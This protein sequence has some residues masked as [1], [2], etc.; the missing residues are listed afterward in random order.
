MPA[1]PPIP[2]SVYVHLPWCPSKCP[3]CDFNSYAAR[4]M[5]ESAYVDALL[6]DLDADAPQVGRRIVQSI[7]VGGGTPSLFESGSIA[8]LLAGLRSRLAL[9]GDVEITLEANP[10]A[11]DAA[12][13][14]G[15]RAAGVNRLSV[16]VQSFRAHQLARLGRVHDAHSACQAAALAREAGFENLNLDLMY[17]LPDDTLEGA[18]E[19]LE[20]AIA[21]EP[22]HISWYQ[23]T[24]EP[25]TAFHRRPP[26]LPPE[27]LVLEIE[28]A[29]RAR[30]AAAGFER[31]EISAYGRPGRR[32][33]HNL[34]YWRFGDYLGLGAG[35]HGKLTRADGTIERYTKKRNP[36]TYMVLAGTPACT[37]T[38]RI[39]DAGSITLE[40]LMNA[41]RLPEGV[42]R[43]LFT[44]RAG[45]S[46]ERIRAP[47]EE[48]ERRGW[49]AAD[50]Q[51]LMPTPLGLQ[52]LNE[53]LR[54]F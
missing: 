18:L 15:Y 53:M 27:S 16:G 50:E 40:F 19:D 41:L 11:V 48:A 10:G 43:S 45:V 9:A 20:M 17:G 47:L 2:L 24:L 4:T 5:P 26:A 14:R 46:L 30:L 33:R 12:R 32:C 28:A 35:A 21:L 3:Y 8:R 7:F 52:S 25:N 49:L 23:L 34:N 6:R 39:T 51:R 31:Y 36:P 22:A 42:K 54:L 38:E 37:E 29:G 44:A 1:R 13:F